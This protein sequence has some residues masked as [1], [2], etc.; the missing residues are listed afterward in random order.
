MPAL[1]SIVIGDE[2]AKPQ[3]KN[4]MDSSSFFAT[5]ASGG[6]YWLS[7]SVSQVELCFDI[8]MW[9]AA[10]V[11]AG[12]F[13]RP[14]TCQRMPQIQRAPHRLTPH[15]LLAIRYVH[16]RGDHAIASIAAA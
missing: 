15:Q 3:P 5:Y 7:D 8:T 1:R 10:R 12:M 11:S 13:S 2:S 14:S 16:A 9:G 4:G 6:K